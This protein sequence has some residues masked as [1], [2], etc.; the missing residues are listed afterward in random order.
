MRFVPN[1]QQKANTTLAVV[2]RF[3]EEDGVWNGGA[4]DLSVAV[5]GDTFEQAMEHMKDAL[6]SHV[7]SVFQSS[8]KDLGEL[9]HRT[10]INL[11]EIAPS[12]PIVKLLVTINR[13]QVAVS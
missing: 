2:C 10:S 5:C 13:Q 7:E 1:K 4:D 3:W 6:Q 9:K 12:S 8:R 11:D